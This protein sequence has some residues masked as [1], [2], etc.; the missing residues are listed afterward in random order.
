MYSYVPTLPVWEDNPRPP[1]LFW[2]I[3]SWD[4]T[5]SNVGNL[6]VFQ[7]DHTFYKLDVKILPANNKITYVRCFGTSERSVRN[8]FENQYNL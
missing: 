7:A 5:D 2:N 8:E 1:G 3:P 6:R 4:D